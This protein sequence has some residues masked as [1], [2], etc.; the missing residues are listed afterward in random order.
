MLRR[1]QQLW[2]YE[3]LISSLIRCAIVRFD[4]ISRL[5]PPLCHRDE[6]EDGRRFRLRVAPSDWLL[7]SRIHS[8]RAMV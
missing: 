6:P 4:S 1:L 3:A 8:R 5:A 7:H 2:L